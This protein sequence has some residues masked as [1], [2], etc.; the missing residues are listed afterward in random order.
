MM[1]I[2]MMISVMVIMMVMTVMTVMMIAMLVMSA[3]HAVVHS[4][5]VGV[6]VDTVGAGHDWHLHV[7]V[8]GRRR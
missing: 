3:D 2:M 6:V 7:L 4:I 8:G 1:G 5:H